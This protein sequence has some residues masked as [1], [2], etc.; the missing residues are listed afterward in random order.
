MLFVVK[1]TVYNPNPPRPDLVR[2]WTFETEAAAKKW[3]DWLVGTPSRY[4]RDLALVV[5][6]RAERLLVE[7]KRSLVMEVVN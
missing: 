2:L 5:G 7:A 3:A 4:A 1:E 6:P